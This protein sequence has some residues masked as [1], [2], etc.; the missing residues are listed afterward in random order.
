M[1][2]GGGAEPCAGMTA[3]IWFRQHVTYRLLFVTDRLHYRLLFNFWS[4]NGLDRN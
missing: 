1:D 4:R 3:R 2:R